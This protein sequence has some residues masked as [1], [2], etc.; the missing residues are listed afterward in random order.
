MAASGQRSTGTTGGHRLADLTSPEIARLASGGA[1]LAVPLGSTEQHGAHLP[2]STDTEIAEQLCV[3]LAGERADVV[4][5]PSVGYGSSGE[6]AGFAGTLSI[7][8]SAIEL[9]VTELGRSATD[10]FGRLLFVSAHGGNSQAVTRAVDTLRA[11]SRDVLL[12]QPRWEGD[13]HAGHTET[14]I[15]L[16]CRP[17]QVS[18]QLAVLGDTRPLAETL[19][20]LRAGGVRAVTSTGVLGDPRGASEEAGRRILDGLA[21]QLIEQVA[22]W[23]ALAHR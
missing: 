4:V 20:L 2:L 12:F 9:L 10:T 16:H 14:S 11:E 17:E 18:M 21:T 7:G 8:Q 5:A 1:M 3:R 19:P 23:H 13:P 6:H 22:A 15:M